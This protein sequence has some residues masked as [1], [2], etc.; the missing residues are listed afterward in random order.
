MPNLTDVERRALDQI[1]CYSKPDH[2]LPAAMRSVIQSLR[3]R[4][5]DWLKHGVWTLT[6]LGEDCLLIE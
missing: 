6:E 1:L 5:L 4:G 3:S 2:M